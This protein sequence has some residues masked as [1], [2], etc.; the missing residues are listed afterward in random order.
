MAYKQKTWWEGELIRLKMW[1][2]WKKTSIIGWGLFILPWLI[3]FVWGAIPIISVN[4]HPVK[5]RAVIVDHCHTGGGKS[6]AR[7][8][9]FYE[10]SYNNTL[11]EGK[12]ETIVNQIYGEIGDTITIRCNK[13]KPSQ[14][15]FNYN[16]YPNYI[17]HR[18][19]DWKEDTEY[20][21]NEPKCNE[22]P[23]L[24]DLF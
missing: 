19:L 4:R 14:S 21:K 3:Y 1:F 17:R 16:D 22:R 23:I 12:F 24:Y 13:N 9:Y 5:V 7:R 10:Y 11:Y 18:V 2:E 20:K 8:C 6:P 15:I